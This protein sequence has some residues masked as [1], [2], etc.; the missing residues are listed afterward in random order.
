[1]K[2][3]YFWIKE[4]DNPQLGTYY[5]AMGNITTKEAKKYESPRLYGSNIMHKYDTKEAYET[6]LF[7]LKREGK[8]IQGI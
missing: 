8:R 3:K 2:G 7:Y 1:M 4:R 6:A 5:V